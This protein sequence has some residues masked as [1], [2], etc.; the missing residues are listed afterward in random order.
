MKKA[1]GKG[2]TMYMLV[3]ENLLNSNNHWTTFINIEQLRTATYNNQNFNAYLQIY[4]FWKYFLH[5]MFGRYHHS[6]N[7]ISIWRFDHFY[8]I[9][10][11]QPI[12]RLIFTY[13]IRWTKFWALYQFYKQH[14][15]WQSVTSKYNMNLL[16][17]G[18]SKIL[19]SKTISHYGFKN[20]FHYGFKNHFS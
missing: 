10:W 15:T 20:H 3:E 6:Y 12:S 2:R 19:V 18:F 8:D 17:I 16:D 7:K 4:I 9:S 1:T 5:K 14:Y 13:L 11:F